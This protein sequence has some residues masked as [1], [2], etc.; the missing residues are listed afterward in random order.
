MIES[1]AIKV[2][3]EVQAT[4]SIARTIAEIAIAMNSDLIAMN[5]TM[6]KK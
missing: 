5:A 3:Y 6:E 4:K 1:D 2:T